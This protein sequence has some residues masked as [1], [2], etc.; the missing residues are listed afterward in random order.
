[1]RAFA[2]LGRR[3]RE[4]A[5]LLYVK[6]LTLREIGEVLGVS[7]SRVCQIHGELKGRLRAA[8]AQDAELLRDVA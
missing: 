4:V 5:V 3:E 6:N 8:L 2:N 7:E 1:R